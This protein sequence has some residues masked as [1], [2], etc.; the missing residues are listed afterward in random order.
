G[1]YKDGVVD[2]SDRHVVFEFRAPFL[3]A[4]TPPNAK[5][6]AIYD[7][8]CKNGLVLRGKARCAVAVSIDDGK[9]WKEAGD[10]RDGLDLTDIVKGRRQYL[11]KLGAVAAELKDTGLTMTTVCQVNSSVLPRLKDDGAKLTFE[12]SRRA[13]VSAGPNLDHAQTH[14]VAGKFGSPQVT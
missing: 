11:L 4:A 7:A 1:P 5:P 6:W 14:V 12:A 10:V 13:L 3:I 8:G 9:T 2:E